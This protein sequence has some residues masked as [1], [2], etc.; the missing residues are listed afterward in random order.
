M[1]KSEVALLLVFSASVEGREATELEVEAWHRLLADVEYEAAAAI[2]ES[3]YRESP[4]RLWPSDV[5]TGI[6]EGVL[7]EDGLS[8]LEARS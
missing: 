2:A 1:K 5:L 4:R 3:H 8:W 6:R 7:A